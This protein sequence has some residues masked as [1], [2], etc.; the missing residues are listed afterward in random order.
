MSFALPQSV[1]M[2]V[3]SIQR[4]CLHDGPGIRTTV[5]LQ[6]C[7]LRCWW[8]HNPKAQAKSCPS[9]NVWHVDQLLETVER[10]A[11][12][13]R[14]SDGGITLS[15]G[16]PLLQA[17]AAETFF[18]EMK[19]RGHHCTIETA[20]AAP[21][22]HVQRLAPWVDLWL[23][24]VKS[25]D[26]DVFHRG[27]EGDVWQVLDNLAWLLNQTEAVVRIR[28]PLIARFNDDERAQALI[29]DWL[30]SQRRV[31][32]VEILPGHDIGRS[33]S[34]LARCSA[35]PDEKHVHTAQQAF[36]SRKLLFQDTA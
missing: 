19:R 20:G 23:W 4:F 29:A 32:P 34:D 15:G 2:R 3:H 17:K 8:C 5:F 13:W 36:A 31:A 28:V 30:V 10:D 6:G 35:K 18:A 1:K 33:S 21:L 16:E 24:D 25:A 11:P 14:S 12:Y 7:S 26:A 9:T 27:T 22:S